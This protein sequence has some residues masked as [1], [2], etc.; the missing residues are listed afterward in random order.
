MFDELII[1]LKVIAAAFCGYMFSE[2]YTKAG[3]ILNGLYLWSENNLPMWLHKP[4]IGC[5]RCVC[6]QWGMWTYFVQT[7]IYHAS[8][9][10]LFHMI[11]CAFLGTAVGIISHKILNDE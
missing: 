7:I 9:F 1:I 5:F 8:D 4:F 10:N 2:Q 3:M 11:A 6:G